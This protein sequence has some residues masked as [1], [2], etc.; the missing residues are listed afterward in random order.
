MPSPFIPLHETV[1]LL[2]DPYRCE[3]L[4][5][6]LQL[7][8]ERISSTN[9]VTTLT[10][11]IRGMALKP[12]T[13]DHAAVERVVDRCRARRKSYHPKLEVK[14]GPLRKVGQVNKRGLVAPTLGGLDTA[15][16]H[17]LG[18]ILVSAHLVY[19]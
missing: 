5:Q 16:E 7:L 8:N 6:F 3:R 15:I 12:T 18:K 17:D 1:S 4:P 13:N 10:L 11:T 14:L 2:H 9:K 19:T